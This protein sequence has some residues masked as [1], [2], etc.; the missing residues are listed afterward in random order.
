MRVPGSKEFLDSVDTAEAYLDREFYGK[1][2]KKEDVNAVCI[3]HTHIDVAWLWTLAQ[4][5]EKVLRSFS[6]VLELMKKYPEYKFMSSQA[7]LYKFLK[8]ESPELYAEVK[9]W[10]A[11]ADGRS[12]APCG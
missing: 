3:G 5:R 11:S 9:E 1:Y 10:Y 8:E 6:T 12:R 4:T 2:C 7:Q